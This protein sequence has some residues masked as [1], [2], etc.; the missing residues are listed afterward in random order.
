MARGGGDLRHVIPSCHAHFTNQ[1]T[2]RVAL[3]N[4]LTDQG[5]DFGNATPSCHAHSPNTLT[6]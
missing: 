1:V 5:G 6:T 3:Y 4:F 2:C